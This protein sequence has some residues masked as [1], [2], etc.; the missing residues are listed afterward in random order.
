MNPED[1]TIG[2]LFFPD[3]AILDG[4]LGLPITALAGL[5]TR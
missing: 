5:N 4:D 2:M 1:V 3:V